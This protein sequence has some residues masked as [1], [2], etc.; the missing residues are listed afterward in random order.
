LPNQFRRGPSQ[1]HRR[2]DFDLHAP[3]GRLFDPFGPR[4]QH[5]RLR[6]SAWPKKVMQREFELRLR[7]GRPGKRR[8][9]KKRARAQRRAATDG[10]SHDEFLLTLSQGIV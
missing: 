2:I 4:L 6:W 8:G 5:L 7:E 10:K 1:R 3:I 9:Y